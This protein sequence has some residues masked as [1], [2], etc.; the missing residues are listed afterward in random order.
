MVALG[1]A[2]VSPV[3]KLESNVIQFARGLGFKFGAI[4]RLAS[5]ACD[6]NGVPDE[7]LD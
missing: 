4:L 7:T 3:L 1:L 2:L 6:C 5:S